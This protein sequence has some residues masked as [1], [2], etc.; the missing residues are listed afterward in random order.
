MKFG[1]N[2]KKLRKSKKMSQET[3]AEKIGVSRQSVSKWETGEAYPEMNNILYLCDIFRCHIN[4][5]VHEDFV[6]INS[7]DEEIKM[8]VIKFK[9]EQ[10]RKMKGI[11]YIIYIISKIGQWFALLGIAILVL[12]FI[13]IPIVG[14][15]IEIKDSEI[16]VYGNTYKYTINDNDIILMNDDNSKLLN[17]QTKTTTDLNSY[18]SG[19]SATYFVICTEIIIICLI[20]SIIFMYLLLRCL[21]NLFKNIH[22]N[23]TPFT[24][25]NVKYIK[26][27][28]LFLILLVIFPMVSGLLFEI[29]TGIDMNISFEIMEV[30]FALIIISLAYIFEYGYQIQLDSNGR[31]YGDNDE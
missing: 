24:L 11:S 23:D 16:E 1:E 7:L 27:M 12:C 31:M 18:I 14:S 5:L 6:D 25:D 10:Q 3:L 26:N 15:N 13:A 2:L 17:I 8:N 22:N 4:D 19:H 28:A 30:V 20:I 21:E 9:N 29:V